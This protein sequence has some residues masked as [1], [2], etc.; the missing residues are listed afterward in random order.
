MSKTI[1]R[2]KRYINWKLRDMTKNVNEKMIPR[3][4]KN[5]PFCQAKS[6]WKNQQAQHKVARKNTNEPK[7]V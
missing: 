6:L 7:E 4:L 5:Q 2:L 3:R 1:G